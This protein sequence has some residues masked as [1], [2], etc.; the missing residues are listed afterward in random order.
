MATEIERKFLVHAN[1]L[2]DLP[3]G[4]VIRQGY[5]STANNI[6]TRIRIIGEQAFLTIKGPS[7]N[8]SRPEFEYPIPLEDAR[9]LLDTLCQP[10]QISKTRYLIPYRDHVWELDIFAGDNEGLIIAEVELGN[11]NEKI[12][13]PDWVGEE[14]S[15]DFRYA[16]SQLT[17]NPYKNW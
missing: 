7:Q 6:T 8:L 12:A 2:G 14:V 17:V 10:C 1:L 16:N 3:E 9:Q 5:L 4:Q 15:H 11:E 13:I